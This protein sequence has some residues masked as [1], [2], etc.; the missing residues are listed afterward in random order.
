M[1]DGLGETAVIF[2]LQ[3]LNVEGF[4]LVESQTIRCPLSSYQPLA[5]GSW[6]SDF[7]MPGDLY[8]MVR[9]VQ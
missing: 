8:S 5:N 6:E 3:S 4:M 7:G 2:Q 9:A 1:G